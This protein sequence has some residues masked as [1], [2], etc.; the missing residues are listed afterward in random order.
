[1]TLSR[2]EELARL[3]PPAGATLSELQAW[4]ALVL[5]HQAALSECEPMRVAAA[6]HIAENARLSPAEQLDLYREQFWLRHTGALL[7]DFPGLSRLL[8]QAAWEPLVEGYL[9]AQGSTVFALTH[10]G[11]H[12]AEH[13]RCADEALFSTTMVPRAA[14]YQMA[15]LEWAYLRA[16]DAEDDATLSPEKLA[17]IPP[18]A[19][20]NARFHISSS[21]TLFHFDYAVADVRRELKNSHGGTEAPFLQRDDHYLVVYRRELSLWDRRI[22]RAA[23]LLLKQLQSGLPLVASCEA[24]IAE[25]PTAEGIFNEQLTEWFTLWGRLGWIVGVET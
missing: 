14:L 5:K 12:L 16:F 24:A 18:T 22:S 25:E 10:L 9:M 17:Q 11:E 7:E 23:Y 19:W 8:G 4:M 2:T 1:M 6:E 13:I 21:V 15:Q 3:A 20:E